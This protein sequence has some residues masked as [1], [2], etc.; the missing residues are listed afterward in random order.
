MALKRRLMPSLTK[1]VAFEAVVRLGSFTRAAEELALTQG[2]LSKQIRQ[3]ESSLG[4]Q[5]LERTKRNLRITPAGR[6]YVNEIRSVL[7]KLERSTTALVAS[8]RRTDVLNI[9]APPSFVD[10]WLMPRLPRFLAQYPKATVNCRTYTVPFDFEQEA[11]DMAIH[12][13]RSNWPDTI[14]LHLF[15]EIVIPVTSSA[16]RDRLRL[17]VPADIERATLIHNSARSALWHI[18]HD[19]LSLNTERPFA[20]HSFDQFLT[21]AEAAAAGL[22]VGLVP[23]ILVDQEI[24]SGKLVKLFGHELRSMESYFLVVPSVKEGDRMTMQFRKWMGSELDPSKR[25]GHPQAAEALDTVPAS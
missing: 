22:G 1:L 2:A 12:C 10:R 5:L 13:G 24:E 11:T 7:W 23:E 8:H 21:V 6:I 25:R 20:G 17:N 3:L 14:A 4:L 19:S 9:A 15:D 18:W 16:Y